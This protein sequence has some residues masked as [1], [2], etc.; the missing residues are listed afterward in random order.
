MIPVGFHHSEITKQ[1]IS[2]ANSGEKHPMFGKHHSEAAKQKMRKAHLGWK[3]SEETRKRMSIAQSERIYP[4][5]WGRKMS[6]ILKGRK[7]T[8][9]HRGKLSLMM[10][11]NQN[12]LGNKASTGRIFS[13]EHRRKISKKKRGENHHNWKGGIS[14]ETSRRVV[15]REWRKLAK[16][17][18]ERDENTCQVCGYEGGNKKL[19]VHHLRPYRIYK[20]DSESNLLTV[21]RSCHQ[22]LDMKFNVTKEKLCT[23]GYPPC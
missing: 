15:S 23:V 18:R 19:C 10:M 12:A 13:E 17:I 16:R 4:E 2:L 1:R 20:D 9:E 8:E 3:P 22:K 14:S 11:G 21:C 6:R 7:F 5:D